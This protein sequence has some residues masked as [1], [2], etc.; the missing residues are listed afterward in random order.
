M[1]LYLGP[2]SQTGHFIC[3]SHRTLHLL[4]TLPVTLP[5]PTCPILLESGN[6]SGG[7][8]LLKRLVSI[9]PGLALLLACAIS[10]RQ[11]VEPWIKLN[12]KLGFDLLH[13]NAMMLSFLLGIALGNLLPR[14][15]WA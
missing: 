9:L 12:W 13:L 10:V 5:C 6:L 4:T 3:Y 1:S 7:S 8:A 2:N 11:F 14:Q 15:A